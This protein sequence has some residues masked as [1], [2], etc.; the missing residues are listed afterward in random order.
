MSYVN[1]VSVS[2][3]SI[4]LKVGKWYYDASAEVCPSDVDCTAV[5]WRSDNISIASVNESSGY[6]YANAVGTTKIHATATDGSGCSDYL[7]VTVTPNIPVSSIVI[8]SIKTTLYPGESMCIEAA[9]YPSNATNRA[10]KWSSNDT[11]VATVD[12][13]TGLVSAQNLGTTTITAK[14]Q[15]GSGVVGTCSISVSAIPVRHISISPEQITLAIGETAHINATIM[16]D[17]ASNK[18]IIWT[19]SDDS[20]ATVETYTG[21]VKAKSSGS[22]KITARTENGYRTDTCDITVIEKV[23]VIKDDEEYFHVVFQ[24]NA[25]WKN[26]GRDLGRVENQSAAFRFDQDHYS[27]LYKYEK[28]YFDNA[29]EQFTTK[30]IAFLYLFDPLGIEYY[31]RNAYG[32]NMS[33]GELLIAKDEIYEHIFG[34]KPRLF[35][36]NDTSGKIKYYTYPNSIEPSTRTQYF[37][38]A[39]ALFGAHVIPNWKIFKEFLNNVMDDIF[40]CGIFETLKYNF[41]DYKN[42]EEYLESMDDHLENAKTILNLVQAMFFEGSVKGI[43]S[44]TVSDFMTKAGAKFGSSVLAGLGWVMKILNILNTHAQTAFNEATLSELNR[45][46]IYE[47]IKNKKAF[48]TEFI[49]DG[50]GITIEDVIAELN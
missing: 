18:T 3:K 47:T 32:S 25:V 24:N 7:T 4:T 37:S 50:C 16:P 31:V 45:K 26:I 30:Q 5:T 9:V 6:I 34:T 40:D 20:V 35:K 13:I 11:N 22:A 49:V 19:S 15:D 8:S 46:D 27:G 12:P 44:S 14:A 1:S 23:E 39:E 10:I 43:Y 28:R 21:V 41:D 33:L 36:E 17:N 42:M 38:E 29:E 2:P 48:R